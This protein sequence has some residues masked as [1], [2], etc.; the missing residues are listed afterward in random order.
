M[1]DLPPQYGIEAQSPYLTQPITDKHTLVGKGKCAGKDLKWAMSSMQG[2]RVTQED[3]HAH[4][5]PIKSNKDLSFFGVFD[6]HGG[7][8]AS[9]Y[10]ASNVLSYIEQTDAYTNFV[11]SG[12]TD[13]ENQASAIAKALM[14]GFIDTDESMKELDVVKTGQDFSGSTGICVMI[15]PTHYIFANTGD[16]RGGLVNNDRVKFTTIDQKPTDPAE[17][18][19]VEA[20]GGTIQDGRVNGDLA[21]ARSFG[22]FRYKLDENLPPSKQQITVL[23]E[24]SIIPRSKDDQFLYLACDGIFDVMSNFECTQMLL[25]AMRLGCGGGVTCERILDECLLKS[26]GD[27]MSLMTIMLP[28]APKEV[29][30]AKP[31][32]EPSLD[33]IRDTMVNTVI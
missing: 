18:A 30:K 2:W 29:G 8:M 1:E 9:Q 14:E 7:S 6:G 17:V 27:N 4:V 19:R 28:N 26:S 31:G 16:S 3:A 15:T 33:V 12:D 24:V 23:P 20:A 10:A 25:S 5:M 22:D 32:R 21:S 11:R 13:P